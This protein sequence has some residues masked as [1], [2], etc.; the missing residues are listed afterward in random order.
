TSE[1]EEAVKAI[2]NGVRE[3]GDKALL[4]YTERFDKVRFSNMRD[5]LCTRQEKE[6]DSS[7][8][9]GYA[10]G[11]GRNICP[12]RQGCLSFNS[13]YERNPCKGCRRQRNNNGTASF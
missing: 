6:R 13:T 4:K 5:A 1:A 10:A 3:N 2:I 7:G 8:A 11:K 12:G 9:E